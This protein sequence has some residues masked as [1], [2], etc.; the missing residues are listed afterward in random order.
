MW[1]RKEH[2][3]DQEKHPGGIEFETAAARVTAASPEIAEAA[4]AV[5]DLENE[6]SLLIKPEWAIVAVKG[7]FYPA[8]KFIHPAYA[9]ADDEAEKISP[10]MQIFLQAIADKYAPAVIAR[11]ANRYPEFWDLVG[12]VG[13]LYYQKWRAISKLIAEEAKA[14]AEAG[15]NAKRVNGEVVF[16]P[17]PAEVSEERVVGQRMRDG[18]L[19]I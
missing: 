9:V 10:Q 18:S 12:A 8:A 2:N 5:I 14:R 15:E 17:S 1:G 3:Q 16:M 11:V 7:C 13:V 4:D 6:E 19:V